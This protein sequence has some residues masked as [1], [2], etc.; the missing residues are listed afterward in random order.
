MDGQS[1]PDHQ[2][3]LAILEFLADYDL[4]L[5]KLSVDISEDDSLLLDVATIIRNFSENDT[6]RWTS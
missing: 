6:S 1:E 2:F 3:W 5:R 4:A